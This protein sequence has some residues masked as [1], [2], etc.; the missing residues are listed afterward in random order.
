MYFIAEITGRAKD[1]NLLLE[2]KFQTEHAMVQL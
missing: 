2:E 1:E